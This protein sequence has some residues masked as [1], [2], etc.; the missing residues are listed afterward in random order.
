MYGMIL[1]INHIMISRYQY[2][3]LNENKY[4]IL[5]DFFFTVFNGMMAHHLILKGGIALSMHNMSLVHL[6]ERDGVPSLMVL[7]VCL[8]VL[9][10]VYV[11]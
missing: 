5:Q 10:N 2:H 7:S 3:S 8:Q 11:S 6:Q 9:Y 4:A 1:N